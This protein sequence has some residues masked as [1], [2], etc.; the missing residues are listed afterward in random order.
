MKKKVLV[1][2]AMI[3]VCCLAMLAGCGPSTE[4]MIRNDLTSQFDDIKN[5]SSDIA[6]EVAES[7]GEDFATIGVDA[8]AFATAYLEGF[9]YAIND[10]T[11]DGDTAT[12]D[13]TV[14]CKSLNS[15][16]NAFQTSF[17]AK[18]NSYDAESLPTEDELNQ[19]AG[20]LL[21]EATEAAEPRETACSFTYTKDDDGTWEA[22]ESASSAMLNAMMA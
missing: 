17:A 13:V 2:L 16:L 1:P 9:D 19:L 11:V 8:K 3:V 20:Q 21:M 7:A 14:T 4:D 6:D 5:D 18:L 10:V 22:D 15:I 12:A